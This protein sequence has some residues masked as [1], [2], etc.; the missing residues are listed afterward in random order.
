MKP[1]AWRPLLLAICALVAII[2]IADVLDITG[3]GG[4]PPWR[5]RWGMNSTESS[6]PFTILVTAVDPGGPADRGG[7]RRGDLI[8]TR[9]NSLI[10]RFWLGA[11]L[12]GRPVKLSVQRGPAHKTLTVTPRPP[13]RASINWGLLIGAFGNLW[14]LLFAAVIAWRRAG[15]P[16]MR[17]LSLWLAMFALGGVDAF[18]SPWP[19]TYIAAAL[20][21]DVG[22]TLIVILWAAIAA[23]FA[24]PLSR[25]RRIAQWLCYASAA[26]PLV[27]YVMRTVNFITFQPY[28]PALTAPVVQ[29][30][31]ALSVFM[32]AAC[33]VLAIMASRGTERQRAIWTMLPIASVLC[34]Y[35]GAGIAF[36]LITPSY[37]AGVVFG[38]V[39]NLAAL[40][41][42]VLLTY[43]ALSRRLIDIGF[44]LNRALVFGL[45]SA[46]VIG[47]FVLVEWAATEWLGS[48][49]YTAGTAFGMALALGLGLSMRY[50]HKHVDRFVD[51]VFFRKRHEDE[52][53]LLRF[54]HESSYVS[55]RST[56]LERAILEVTQHTDAAGATILVS[57]GASAFASAKETEPPPIVS[58]NDPAIL[59]LRAWRKPL[60][61]A[62]LQ[63]SDLRGE[64]AFPMISRGLLIGILVCEAKRNGEG[65]AP[66]ESEALRTL[67]HSVGTALDVLSSTQ[68]DHSSEVVLRE[69]ARLR[70]DVNRLQQA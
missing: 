54:A 65:Y 52:A 10:E 25:A 33:G 17:L 24:Q 49:G 28:T 45:V 35:V 11:A 69:L 43:A 55:D 44:V 32:A 47:L 8:D 67:A 70:A 36:N 37:A 9:A 48:I 60:D 6:K 63:G 5:G 31:T 30:L 22:G 14:L 41:A 68:R 19:W 62:S 57:N 64:I 16:Q 61:L 38:F 34:L 56:L 4:A 39:V 46:I 53:A 18:A 1:S 7:L 42:P 21:S 40:A 27:L 20:A 3:M 13:V 12:N 23:G 15:V 59:A 66:D 51:N 29:S 50:I 2:Q 58:E 26:I